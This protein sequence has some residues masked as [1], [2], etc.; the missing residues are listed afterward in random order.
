MRSF[1]SAERARAYQPAA[2]PPPAT[3]PVP[4]EPAA[5]PPPPVPAAP[6][7]PAPEQR[8]VSKRHFFVQLRVPPGRLPM[9]ADAHVS[10]FRFLLSHC[11]SRSMRLFPQRLP[12]DEASSSP[13]MSSTAPHAPSRDRPSNTDKPAA[14]TFMGCSFS[15][16]AKSRSLRLCFRRNAGAAHTTRPYHHLLCRL[17]PKSTRTFFRMSQITVRFKRSRASGPQRS[18]GGPPSRL[19]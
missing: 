11:S 9:V 18:Q 6:P 8:F 2:P 12:R 15:A 7:V 1:H 19:H 3:P 10:P 4:A 16:D 17:P 14:K 5:P 13:V